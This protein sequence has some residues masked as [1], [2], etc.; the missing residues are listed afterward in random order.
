MHGEDAEGRDRQSEG[1]S[2]GMTSGRLKL[3]R[4]ANCD[5]TS[6][7]ALAEYKHYEEL[8]QQTRELTG[9]QYD[10]MPH[11]TGISNPTEQ[12][13]LKVLELEAEYS[14]HV[15]YI[16]ARVVGDLEIKRLVDEV[17]LRFP[18]IYSQLATLR[19]KCGYTWYRVASALYVSE[20]TARRMDKSRVDAIERM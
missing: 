9:V 16:L 19:Y 6:R 13:A 14:A 17:L 3:Y 11:A 20:P 1:V 15:E 18:P 12:K 4:W 10:G 7:K 2:A 8:V 5:D